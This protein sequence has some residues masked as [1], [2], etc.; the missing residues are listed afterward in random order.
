MKVF[1]F[2]LQL[3]TLAEDLLTF[4]ICRKCLGFII[5]MDCVLCE[6]S[7]GAEKTAFNIETVFSLWYELK[8]I[9]R[10]NIEQSL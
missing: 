6:V 10:L 1:R 2:C 9:G 3:H 4:V 7:A 8:M 5:E